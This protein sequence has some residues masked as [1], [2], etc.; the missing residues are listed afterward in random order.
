MN[1]EA[2]KPFYAAIASKEFAPSNRQ[3]LL[4]RQIH[5]AST[6]EA[7]ATA[8]QRLQA[9]MNPKSPITIQGNATAGK[10]LLEAGMLLFD[11]AKQIGSDISAAVQAGVLKPTDRAVIAAVGVWSKLVKKAE[12]LIER[13]TTALQSVVSIFASNPKAA[14]EVPQE[15]RAAVAQS[16]EDASV[17]KDAMN[18]H[19]SGFMSEVG[20]YAFAAMDMAADAL[21]PVGK[22]FEDMRSA[23]VDRVTA[24]ARVY[25]QHVDARRQSAQ[26]SREA[27]P[28]Y[29]SEIE[30]RRA[31]LVNVGMAQVQALK[32]AQPEAAVVEQAAQSASEAATTLVQAKVVERLE[33][34][35]EHDQALADEHVEAA[36]EKTISLSSIFQRMSDTA[37]ASV[38]VE[39]TMGADVSADEGLTA[40][41][42]M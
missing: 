33:P 12:S 41:P 3:F 24:G 29:V 7:R 23:L 2:L 21:A 42:T 38:R 1:T 4:A 17:A 14:Q 8:A 20:V 39:P 25:M 37:A 27:P 9:F 16:L 13:A 26:A 22:R 5:L 40:G 10:K 19:S 34:A 28:A 30:A 36:D 11:A 32:A 35:V 15:A 6:E 31:A 18:K